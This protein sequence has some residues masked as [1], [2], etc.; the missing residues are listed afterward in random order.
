MV[1]SHF[2]SILQ[3]LKLIDKKKKILALSVLLTGILITISLMFVISNEIRKNAKKDFEYVCKD[4]E[5]RIISRL[6]LNAELL[7]S[8]SVLFDVSQKITRQDWK[9]IYEK[10][11]VDQ[12]LP[13]MLAIGYQELVPYSKLSEHERSIRNEGFPNY[14]VI[15]SGIREFY[16]PI[17]FIEPFVGSNL[18][19]FGYDTYSEPVRR[20]AMEIARDYNIA[21]LTDKITLVQESQTNVQAGFIMF[22][23]VYKKDFPIST[24]EERRKAIKGWISNPHRM[25]DLMLGIL[26]NIQALRG[27]NIHLQIYDNPAY[28]I[29]GLLFDSEKGGKN[30]NLSNS[31]FRSNSTISFHEHKW[32]L[33]FDQD[34]SYP[35]IIDYSKIWYTFY[36]GITIS[37]LIFIFLI[38]LMNTNSIASN[39]ARN[40]TKELAESEAKYKIIF[41]NSIFAISMIDIE[42]KTYLDVNDTQCEMYGYNRKEFL[43]GMS[44]TDISSEPEISELS[45]Y[46]T[47]EKGN[48][49]IPLRYHKKKDGTIFPVEVVGGVQ[50]WKNKP[51]MFVIVNDITE[52]KIT[53]KKIESL[54]ISYQTLLQ[55]S[56][57]GIHVIDTNGNV[58]E[59]NDSFCDLLGYTNEE[60]LKLNVSDWDIQWNKEE[61]LLKIKELIKNSSV[62]ETRHKC[63]DGKIKDVEISGVGVCI[64]GIEYLYASCRDVTER[65]TAERKLLESE[66]RWQFALE[67]SGDGVWDWDIQTN[68]VF[69]SDAWKIM[70]G[71][72]VDEIENKLDEWSKRVHPDDLKKCTEDIENHFNGTTPVYINEHRVLCKNGEYKWVLDRGKIVSRSESGKPLRMIGTHADISDRKKTE[73]LLFAQAQ[74]L[75]ELNTKLSL[76]IEKQKDYEIILLRALEKEK[77][78]NTLKTRIIS[79]TSHEFRTPLANINA[80]VDI[81]RMFGEKWTPKKTNEQID[82]I[83]YFV[84]HLTSLLDDALT[85]SKIENKNLVFKPESVDLYLLARESMNDVMYLANKKHKFE[86]EFN[87]ER[88]IFYLDSIFIKYILINLL[89][90]AIKYSPKGGKIKLVI[91]YQK[92]NLI[93]EVSDSGIGINNREFKKIFEPFYRSTD[94]EKIAGNGLGLGIVKHGVEIHEGKISITSAKGEGSTFTVKIPQKVNVNTLE[95]IDEKK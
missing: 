85:I 2:K 81:L 87:A 24:V 68:N 83:K 91:N 43:S 7:S 17:V 14:K 22:L 9:N 57:D 34:L 47:I 80:S 69:F 8:Q 21:A 89:S 75:N 93:I 86:F 60:I 4:I 29:S 5:Y 52:R 67:G 71:F 74:E 42:T 51:V 48:L 26:G 39:L 72:N 36:S 70:L 35:V 88:K 15:P 10:R 16:T 31:D 50:Y 95:H 49:F 20:K 28:S 78:I 1:N 30:K 23:P 61:L 3:S 63:K 37:F 40:L 12:T 55:A 11:K 77:E 92:S 66:R 46:T 76:E 62:F 19:A 56:K 53:E 44:V 13:G 65:K 45:F 38:A 25:D 79:T 59:A 27:K 41:N 32:Y 6:K 84:K 33:K 64:N 18:K 73:K 90:N 82:R 94:V 54:A 58:I